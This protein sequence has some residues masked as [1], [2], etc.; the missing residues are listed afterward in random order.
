MR[1]LK[2]LIPI[3][4]IGVPIA[5]IAT[6]IQVGD[7]I[8]LWPT[9]LTIVLTAVIGTA[10]LRRQ[11][12]ATLA[13][14]QST[15][16]EGQL[17][18]ESVVH[19]VFLLI[20]GVLLLTP[21]FLTDG[22]GFALLV[23]PVRLWLAHWLFEKIRNSKSVHVEGFSNGRSSSSPFDGTRD[24]GPIIDGEIIDGEIIEETPPPKRDAGSGSPWQR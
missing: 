10:I 23:P 20:A 15:L 14:A 5:E 22:V 24:D 16:N 2:F 9:L 6:F 7:V 11:G 4:F 18:L 1:V 13:T 21:G 12:L 8:G 19:A 17:P 3:V